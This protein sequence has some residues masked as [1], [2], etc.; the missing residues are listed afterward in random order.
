VGNR[1]GVA[2][3]IFLPFAR[4]Y[5]AGISRASW[6]WACGSGDGRRHSAGRWF[7][8]DPDP[9]FRFEMNRDERDRPAACS[10]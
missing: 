10:F 2:E 3:I 7:E 1:F 4:T 9:R 6:P 5:F 8:T